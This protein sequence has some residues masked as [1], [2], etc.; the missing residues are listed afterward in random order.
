MRRSPGW[1]RME[2]EPPAWTAHTEHARNVCEHNS[3]HQR[4]QT[5]LEGTCERLYE[6]VYFLEVA[7]QE[8]EKRE[9]AK[10]A[11]AE[12]ERRRAEAAEAEA[13]QLRIDLGRERRA[14]AEALAEA[15]HVAARAEEKHTAELHE[16]K[17]RFH[18]EAHGGRSARLQLRDARAQA[19]AAEAAI[20]HTRAAWAERTRGDEAE[21]RAKALQE[22]VWELEAEARDHRDRGAHRERSVHLS[23]MQDTCRWCRQKLAISGPPGIPSSPRLPPLVGSVR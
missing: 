3:A 7:L 21:S 4:R 23:T 12:T 20:E 18:Q 8:A 16:H 10:R 6:R 14:N 22:R 1:A 9:D 11:E 19:E 5:Q 17:R 13:D 15:A 2:D